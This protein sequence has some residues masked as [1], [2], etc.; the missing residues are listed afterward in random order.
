MDNPPLQA[1]T[2]LLWSCMV[3]ERME[4]QC[5][6]IAMSPQQRIRAVIWNLDGVILRRTSGSDQPPRF[7]TMGSLRHPSMNNREIDQNLLEFIAAMRRSVHTALLVNTWGE[8]WEIVS[9]KDS[10]T[11]AFDR[12]I[13]AMDTG[14]HRP[15]ARIFTMAAIRMGISPGEAA[16]VDADHQHVAAAR[17]AGMTAFTFENPAQIGSALMGLLAEHVN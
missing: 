11:P 5:E 17:Q 6:V 10:L 7:G 1:G 8:V 16:L 9:L 13:Q 15:D 14:L 4:E 2:I 12:V 3:Q